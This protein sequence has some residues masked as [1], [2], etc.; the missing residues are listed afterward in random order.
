MTREAQTPEQLFDAL[1]AAEPGRPFV[2]FYDESTG[3]RSELSARSLGNWV[4]K[5]HFLL[6]DELGLGVGDSALVALPAHWISV[7]ALLGCLTAGLALTR[8]AGDAAVA[9]VEPA[10]AAQA[11]GVPDVYA[12][13]PDSA[14]VGLRDDT[15]PG[16]ADYVSAVRPQPDKWPTV[17]LSASAGDPGLDGRSRGEVVAWARQRAA[18]LGLTAGSRVITTREWHGP[19]DWLDT[20]LAPLAV[21]GSVVYVRHAQDDAVVE[22]RA[23][24]ER[25]TVRV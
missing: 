15:P 23:A 10:T 2:T 7:P 13:A 9:F 20:L 6:I 24:Q 22:H 3:E 17:Q 14:A 19:D 16:V 18:E 8:D 25:A 4:A 12:V 5:T 11:T 21:G 1:L